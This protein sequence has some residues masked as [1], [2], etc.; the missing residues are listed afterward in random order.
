MGEDS[1]EALA[2]LGIVTAGSERGPE[3]SLVPRDRAFHLPA[4]TIDRAVEATFHLPS[5]LRARPLPP[6]SSRVQVDDRRAHA[7]FLA[8][9]RVIVL[10][11]VTRVGEQPVDLHQSSRAPHGLGEL[12]R[13]LARPVA[14]HGARPQVRRA[15][16]HHRE[17]G[18]RVPLESLVSRAFDVVPRDMAAFQARRVDDRLGRLVDQAAARRLDEDGIQEPIERPPLRS[19]FSA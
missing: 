14:H 19:R 13:V 18:P 3:A 4:L 9:Q 5:I 12:R 7:Q 2:L 17:F 15:V 10:G 16:A 1:E 11:V 6:R 8:R